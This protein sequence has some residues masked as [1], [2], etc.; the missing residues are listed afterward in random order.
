MLAVPSTFLLGWLGVVVV[1]RELERAPF[2]WDTWGGFSVGAL[3]AWLMLNRAQIPKLRTFVH[4]SKHAILVN[5]IGGR[6]KKFE[7]SAEQGLVE[8]EIQEDVSHLAPL[9]VLAPYFF[10]LFSLPTFVL[11][12]F[13]GES[14][15]LLFAI[16]LGFALATDI[17]SGFG[18]MRPEQTDFQAIFGGFALCGSY[19]AGFHFM[20]TMVCLVWISNGRQ[21]FIQGGE[22]VLELITYLVTVAH[23]RA[24]RFVNEL[25]PAG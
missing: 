12:L 17:L 22:L 8:Y 7:V 9:I 24:V 16:A 3:L 15:P 11:T 13:L 4:E 25:F 1:L 23:P 18:E 19:L 20:W 21:A 14:D 2:R 6:V 10:P 5:L